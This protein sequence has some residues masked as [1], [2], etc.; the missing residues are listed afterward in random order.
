MSTRTLSH[1]ELA[2][3]GEALYRDRIAPHLSPSDERKYVLIDV[4]SGDFEVDHDEMR[5]AERLRQRRPEAQVWFR[6]VGSRVVRH[7][8]RRRTTRSR[9]R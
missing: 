5:A 1:D 8:G 7:Y 6:R 2:R 9:E 4:E 3:R